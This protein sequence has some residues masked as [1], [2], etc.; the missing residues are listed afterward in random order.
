MIAD[1]ELRLRSAERAAYLQAEVRK[2]CLADPSV[3]TLVDCTPAELDGFVCGVVAL[4]EDQI[5]V[6]AE[7]FGIE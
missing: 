7:E 4:T 6:L 3:G 2:A 5:A 1:H